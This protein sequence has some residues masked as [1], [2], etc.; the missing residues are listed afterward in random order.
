MHLGNG[1]DQTCE[2]LW[3]R[4]D[5]MVQVE[6]QCMIGLVGGRECDARNFGSEGL[7]KRSIALFTDMVGHMVGVVI[8]IIF[9]LVSVP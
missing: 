8:H 7:K 5:A 2:K 1:R 9:S 4:T 3:S 6:G